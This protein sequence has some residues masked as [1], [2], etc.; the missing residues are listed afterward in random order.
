MIFDWNFE[1]AML[2]WTDAPLIRDVAKSQDQDHALIAI[3]VADSRAAYLF[4][5]NA[6]RKHICC[7]TF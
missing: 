5:P 6:W 2:D 7:S 4:N 1:S 3:L